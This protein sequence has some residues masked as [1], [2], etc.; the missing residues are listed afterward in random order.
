MVQLSSRYMIPGEAIAL[1]LTIRTFCQQRDG[2]AFHMLSKLVHVFSDYN[3]KQ[4]FL[5]NE[6]ICQ[7]EMAH[8]IFLSGGSLTCPDRAKIGST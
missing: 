3:L 7:G 8:C 5:S 6:Y 4:L 2:S 1:A